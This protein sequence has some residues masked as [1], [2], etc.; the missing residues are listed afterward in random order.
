MQTK[1]WFE[2]SKQGL[3][4]LQDGKPKHY[5]AR[6]LI[7]NAWDEKIAIC[8]FIATYSKG[9]AQFIVNDD[10]PEG[11]KNLTDAYTL[12]APTVDPNVFPTYVFS[13]PCKLGTVS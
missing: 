8:D 9:I 11:F 1:N 6:E 4:E 12:F 3:K 2:V 7:Q 5:A 13:S 10:N